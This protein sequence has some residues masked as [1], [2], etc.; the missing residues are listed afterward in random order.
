MENKVFYIVECRYN[1]SEVISCCYMSDDMNKIMLWLSNN[2]DFDLK[3]S[4]YWAI[5]QIVSDNEYGA[6]IYKY[7]DVMLNELDEQP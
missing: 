3:R 7:Y 5:L 4:F 6:V 2:D 1:P